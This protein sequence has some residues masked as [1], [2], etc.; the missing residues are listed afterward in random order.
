MS[1]FLVSDGFTIRPSQYCF[2]SW[3][4]MFKVDFWSIRT[5][6]LVV[7]MVLDLELAQSSLLSITV[8]SIALFKLWLSAL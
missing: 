4:R 3:G 6:D 5:E 2:E 7:T 1:R 8:V